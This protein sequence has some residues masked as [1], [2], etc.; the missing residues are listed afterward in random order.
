MY[1]TVMFYL[2]AGLAYPFYWAYYRTLSIRVTNPQYGHL[3]EPSKSVVYACWHSKTFVLLP[4]GSGQPVAILTL[5][6]W[7]NFFYDK[8]CR[9]FGYR[10]VSV[11]NEAMATRHLIRYLKDGISVL[12]A[13]DGPV[14]PRGVI[15]PGVPFLAAISK[16]PIV[17]FKVEMEKSFRIKSRWDLYEI[18]Y[19]F[20]RVH[21][22]L[23]E[24]F[25]VDTSDLPHASDK[26]QLLLGAP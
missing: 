25:L 19:P 6:D 26:I 4:Y 20:S 18:P 13:V 2:L 16:K 22:V 11:R 3:L 8:L 12:L 17:V 15:R 7:K 9:L 23:S 24:P 5:L 14:G 10:S 21:L 1:K